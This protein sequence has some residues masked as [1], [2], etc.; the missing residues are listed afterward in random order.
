VTSPTTDP[1]VHFYLSSPVQFRMSLDTKRH[2]PADGSIG[3]RDFLDDANECRRISFLAAQRSG[4]PLAEQARSCH[5]LNEWHR[6]APCLLNL[7]G[8]LAYPWCQCLGSVHKP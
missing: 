5:A 4:N 2:A 7:P 8:K 6:K 1:V 3:P